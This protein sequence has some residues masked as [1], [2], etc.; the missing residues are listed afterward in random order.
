MIFKRSKNKD[1]SMKLVPNVPIRW[2][3][4]RL[5]LKP[6]RLE[7]YI[8]WIDVRERSRAHLQPWEPTWAQDVLTKESFEKRVAFNQHQ[9]D[10]SLGFCMLAHRKEDHKIVA[11]VNLTQI[12]NTASMSMGVLGY[13][14]GAPYTRQGYTYEAV[15]KMIQMAFG[16]MRVLR[17]QAACMLSNKPSMALLEKA[18]FT[19]EGIARNYL[20]ICDEWTDQKIFSLLKS[21][22]YGATKT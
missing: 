1:G 14:C 2:E 12:R 11:G 4:K 8:D 19:E 22:L 18:G 5:I 10:K 21:D 3:T 17:I 6:Y 9:W 13:W 15:V 20:R 7:D 16:P